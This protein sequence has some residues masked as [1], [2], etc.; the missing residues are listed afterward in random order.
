[1]SVHKSPVPHSAGSRLWL[2]ENMGFWKISSVGLAEDPQHDAFSEQELSNSFL[3][4]PCPHTYPFLICAF[5]TLLAVP[6]SHP[7]LSFSLGW[8]CPL[9]LP[10]NKTGSLPNEFSLSLSFFPPHYSINDDSCPSIRPPR[11]DVFNQ[12]I[13]ELKVSSPKE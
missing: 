1:M 13:M 5:S 4:L 7:D 11:E 3:S 12:Q 6:E 10:S 9:H 2:A 8:P